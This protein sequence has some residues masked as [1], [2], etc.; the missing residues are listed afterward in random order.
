MEYH[1]SRFR[2]HYYYYSRELCIDYVQLIVVPIANLGS[3]RK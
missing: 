2:N 3:Y 1:S